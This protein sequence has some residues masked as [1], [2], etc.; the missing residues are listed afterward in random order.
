M[1]DSELMRSVMAAQASGVAVVAARAGSHDLAM[2]ISSLV[3]VSLEPPMV[4]FTVYRDSR[5]AEAVE[6]GSKW[7]VSLL[8][9]EALPDARWLSEPGRP[10]L[11]QLTG[12]AHTRGEYSGAALL[13]S[14]TVHL[15]CET[16]WIQPAGTHEVV[17][18][19][20]MTAAAVSGN[21]G[22]IVHH[23]GQLRSS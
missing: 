6:P 5:F 15:E 10:L 21:S 17:V 4:L 11:G 16:Q 12:V 2:T 14:A 18:G 23:R 7:A 20:V 13:A 22:Y 1:V 9:D 8:G 19:K 3:S